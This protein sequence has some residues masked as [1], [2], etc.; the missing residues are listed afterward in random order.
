[1]TKLLRNFRSHAEL[2]RLPN[3]LF[4]DNELLPC[5]DPMLA[6]SCLDWESLPNPRVPMI[7]HGIEGKD[8]REN[9]SPSWFNADEALLVLDYVPQHVNSATARCPTWA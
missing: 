2:L 7:F 5:A 8:E 4:Y 1:M 6:N 9:N 3:Q